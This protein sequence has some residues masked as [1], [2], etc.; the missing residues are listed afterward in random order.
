MSGASVTLTAPSSGASGTFSNGTDTITATTGT[1]GQLSENFTANF[2]GGSYTVGATTPGATSPADFSLLNGMNFSISGNTSTPFYP[3]T[4]ESVDLSISNPNPG[5]DELTVSSSSLSLVVTPDAA[6]ASCQASWFTLNPGSW[7]VSVQGG[8]T[9]PL[10]DLGVAMGNL[11][12][13]TMTDVNSPQDACKGASLSLHWS[14][15][16]NGAP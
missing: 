16:G 6:H 10:S 13:V 4:T 8:T 3:G 14:A 15:N 12:T 7:S 1:N 5:S 11:P 9:E 2:I